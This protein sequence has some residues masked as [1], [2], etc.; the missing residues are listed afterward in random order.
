MQITSHTL[1]SNE[2]SKQEVFHRWD[3]IITWSVKQS[4]KR[5][6]SALQFSVDRKLQP[7]A[8]VLIDGGGQ[9]IVIR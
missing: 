8:A 6:F 5:P 7:A 9:S 2:N 3:F 4:A 1:K